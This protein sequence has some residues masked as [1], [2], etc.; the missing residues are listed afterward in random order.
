MTEITAMIYETAQN[1]TA[2]LSDKNAASVEIISNK[3]GSVTI[4]SLPINHIFI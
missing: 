3:L 4:N 1:I 2:A